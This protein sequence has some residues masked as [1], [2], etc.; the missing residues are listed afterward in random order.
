VKECEPNPN[1]ERTRKELTLMTLE[2]V[3]GANTDLMWTDMWPSPIKRVDLHVPSVCMSLMRFRGD[4]LLIWMAVSQNPI[5]RVT[6]EELTLMF[7]EPV[8]FEIV[9]GI[10]PDVNECESKSSKERDQGRVDPLFLEPV[11]V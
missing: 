10:W 5:R 9:I 2:Y 4:T 1:E 3:K 8:T 6:R 7:L 11:T